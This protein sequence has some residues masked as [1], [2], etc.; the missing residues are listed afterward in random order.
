MYE[1]ESLSHSSGAQ[2]LFVCSC[3][4]GSFDVRS[5]VEISV[6]SPLN[7]I[8]HPRHCRPSFEIQLPNGVSA[9]NYIILG[10]MTHFVSWSEL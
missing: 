9:S 7:V 3:G 8:I 4:S 5:S 2:V 10:H 1:G 6:L